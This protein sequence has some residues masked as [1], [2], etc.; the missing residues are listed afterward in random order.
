[1]AILRSRRLFA[2]FINPTTS[3]DGTVLPELEPNP[4]G[5][6]E[7]ARVADPRVVTSVY[8]CPAGQRAIFRSLT[9][10]LHVTPA[11]G[12]EPTYTWMITGGV[13]KVHWFWFVDHASQIAVW[14]LTE[15][16]NTMLVLHEN[17]PM[18][19][20]LLSPVA[21]HVQGSGHLLPI[22]S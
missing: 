1:M 8:T 18:Y 14:R 22:N 20:E 11:G 17:E 3:N 19:I 2:A 6:D 5:L 15:T 13:Y 21:A 7:G 16:W 12:S 4:A 10:T 9:V